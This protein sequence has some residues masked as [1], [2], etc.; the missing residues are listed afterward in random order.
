MRCVPKIPKLLRWYGFKKMSGEDV[1][2]LH[3]PRIGGVY[4]Y[5]VD[6]GFE[7]RFSD[8]DTLFFVKRSRDLARYLQRFGLGRVEG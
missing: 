8:F 6:D 4:V 5:R 3:H 7:V 1:W 2:V